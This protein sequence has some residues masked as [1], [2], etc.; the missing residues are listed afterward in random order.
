MS[1]FNHHA[2]AGRAIATGTTILED[3]GS[4]GTINARGIDNGAVLHSTGALYLPV[5]STGQRILVVAGGAFNVVDPATTLVAT[6]ASGEI[7]ECLCVGGNVWV[8][9][10]F[11]TGLS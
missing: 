6:M 7:C 5:G 1:V 10:M 3:P 9:C 8:G 4:G 2:E 11:K